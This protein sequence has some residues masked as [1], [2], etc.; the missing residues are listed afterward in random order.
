MIEDRQGNRG[1]T[2]VNFTALKELQKAVTL[3]GPH[4]NFT[5]AILGTLGTQGLVP[6]DWRNVCKAV[7]SGGGYLLWSA[8]CRE[9]ART[10]AAQN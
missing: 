1:W 8:A 5:K 3:Y 7:L 4:A 9:L 6:E 10:Q 2:P